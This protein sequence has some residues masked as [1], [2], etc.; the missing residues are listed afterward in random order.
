MRKRA[1]LVVGAA[2]LLGVLA[3]SWG[4]WL[5]T[6]P[7]GSSTDES[8]GEETTTLVRVSTGMTLT[9]AADTLV[10]RGLLKHSKVLLM[11]ARLTG[12]DRSLRAGLFKLSYGESPRDLL[13][14]LTSGSAVQVKVTLPEGL[15]AEEV[16][17]IMGEAL[18]FGPDD[19]LAVADSL[20]MDASERGRLLGNGSGAV[21]AHDSLL[22]AES[23]RHPRTFRWCEGHLAPDTFL[24]AE[25]TTAATAAGFLVKTQWARLDSVRT[26]AAGTGTGD[27]S[28]QDLLTLAS[29]VEAEARRA[30][31]RALI[32]AVYVNRLRRGRRL[33]AD[34]TVAF[35]LLKKGKRLYYRDLEVDSPFNTYRNKGLPPGPIGNPGRAALWAA[36]HPDSTCYAMFFVSDGEGGHVFSRTSTEHEA[37][38]RE[39][40]RIRAGQ[41]DHRNN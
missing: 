24:F 6:G 3:V 34:P 17:A 32:S 37:A 27:F 31:E 9:A 30:D 8:T 40:R 33:E 26:A 5:W 2:F 38:V 21:A 39:F 13:Q 28:R 35:I 25:G 4:W 36:A 11:G 18:G 29:I 1:L 22:Q 15:A 41:G 14:A 7:D 20:V 16:A 12:K 19:F 23:A 10:A